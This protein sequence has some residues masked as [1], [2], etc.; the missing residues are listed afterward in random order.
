MNQPNSYRNR[1]RILFGVWCVAGLVILAAAYSPQLRTREKNRLGVETLTAAR[2]AL[3]QAK[4][5]K[6]GSEEQGKLLALAAKLADESASIFSMES[7]DATVVAKVERARVDLESGRAFEA[8]GA[9][10]NLSDADRPGPD[11]L[12]SA[13]TPIIESA[14]AETR[15]K[16]ALMCRAE[17]DGYEN[18][19]KYAEAAA[20][21]Y[22]VLAEKASSSGDTDEEMYLKN[23]ATCTR[24]INGRDE[25]NHSLGFPTRPTP[26]CVMVAR[27]WK[28]P[29]PSGGSGSSNQ[30]PVESPTTPAPPPEPN[31]T[32]KGR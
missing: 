22:Q 21:S 20:R 8:L 26:D 14:L 9:L 18:W 17:G 13:N 6:K 25:D 15:Y 28:R 29:P 5:S 4:S 1:W 31:E 7:A 30:D 27:R 2:A 10:M 19:S 32:T 16:I 3:D 23:L 11:A 12:W 24:L